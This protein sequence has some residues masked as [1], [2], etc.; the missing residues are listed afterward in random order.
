MIDYMNNT[1]S[2]CN[3]SFYANKKDKENFINNL[4]DRITNLKNKINKIIN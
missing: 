1:I 2:I 4:K 3:I